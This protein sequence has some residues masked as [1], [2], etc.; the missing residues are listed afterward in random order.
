MDFR[1]VFEKITPG[2]IVRWMLSAA[3]LTALL[4]IGFYVAGK[5]SERRYF[6]AAGSSSETEAEVR[7]FVPGIN[8]L[9]IPEELN[10]SARFEWQP[11]R[12]TPEKWG[13][14]EIQR[15]WIDPFDAVADA[16]A[17]EI[18]KH[19]DEILEEIP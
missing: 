19:L 18:R 1:N 11:Y 9:K 8:D 6:S 17:E 14:E 12:E 16:Y 2:R 4:L 7:F 15:F 10:E 5:I 3:A 13:D